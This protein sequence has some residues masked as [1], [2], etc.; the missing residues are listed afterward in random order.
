MWKSKVKN[1]KLGQI[2][3]HK[4]N[5]R[6][7]QVVEIHKMNNRIVLETK[8]KIGMHRNDVLNDL[9]PLLK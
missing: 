3:V 9:E 2:L 6:T 8:M 7:Y 4:E 1:I 5:N